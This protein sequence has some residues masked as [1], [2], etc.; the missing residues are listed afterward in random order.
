MNRTLGS[1]LLFLLLGLAGCWDA[2]NTGLTSIEYTCGDEEKEEQEACDGDD[3]GGLACQDVAV[4]GVPGQT[5]YRGELGCSSDCM[6][7]L[8]DGCSGWCGDD[9]WDPPGTGGWETCDGVDLGDKDCQDFVVPGHPGQQFYRGDLACAADC[10]SYDLGA[11]EGF[12]GDAVIDEDAPGTPEVCDGPAIAGAVCQDI[13]VAGVPGK[14]YYFGEPAC[15][16]NCR[17]WVRGTCEGYCGDSVIQEDAPGTPEICDS[18]NVGTLACSELP[19]P[20]HPGKFFYHGTPTCTDDC[21]EVTSE[22]CWGYCGNDT[23]EEMADGDWEVCDGADLGGAVCPDNCLAGQPICNGDCLGL[24]TSTDVQSGCHMCCGDDVCEDG[25]DD[26]SCAECYEAAVVSY[27]DGS[28][29]VTEDSCEEITDTEICSCGCDENGC[30]AGTTVAGEC[31]GDY[32]NAF[33]E[34]GDLVGST[35]CECGCGSNGCNNEYD[36]CVDETMIVELENKTPI[37]LKLYYYP[38]GEIDWNCNS[39]DAAAANLNCVGPQTNKSPSVTL[40]PG[41]K[42]V[43]TAPANVLVTEKVYGCGWD[44]DNFIHWCS[45]INC[46]K[47]VPECDMAYEPFFINYTPG[48]GETCSGGTFDSSCN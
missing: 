22:A 10:G 6:E 16:A 23:R 11:C 47:N 25:E 27:C 17:D 21:D 13:E 43:I 24:D 30:L 31:S 45:H 15:G 9:T 1:T 40:A 48:A 28:N 5:Y 39:S 18:Y 33:D 2:G 46:C 7:L 3:T 19:V 41:E 44:G 12:C 4:P 20:D 42:K 26:C 32:W 29:W 8:T 37:S 34:C 38:W 14:H 35:F 36:C